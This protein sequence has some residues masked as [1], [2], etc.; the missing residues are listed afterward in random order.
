MSAMS[1]D[2]NHTER[3]WSDLKTVFGKDL[4]QLEKESGLKF[5][6]RGVRNSLVVTGS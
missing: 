6:Y 4:K 5:Q 3:L 2:L 1:P